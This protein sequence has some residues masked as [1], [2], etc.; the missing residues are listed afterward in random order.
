MTSRFDDRFQ[1]HGVPVVNREF[2]VTVC[3]SRGSITSPDFS[4][5]RGQRS[6]ESMGGVIGL[7][8]RVERRDY[9]LPIASTTVDGRTVEPRATDRITEGSSVWEVHYP[10]DT[11][12]A[13]EKLGEYEWVAHTRLIE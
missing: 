6:H 5:R 4:A 2:S 8:V 7:D 1:N 13:A 9:I 12:P 11:T 3:F 10:D